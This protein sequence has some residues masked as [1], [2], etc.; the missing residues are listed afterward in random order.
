[1]LVQTLLQSS[2][3]HLEEEEIMQDGRFG[4][5]SFLMSLPRYHAMWHVYH[6]IIASCKHDDSEC[7]RSYIKLLLG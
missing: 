1:V 7:N 5:G 2:E 3:T 6:G 4:V